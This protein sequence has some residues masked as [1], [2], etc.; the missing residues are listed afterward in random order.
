MSDKPER[1]GSREAEGERSV[2]AN[3]LALEQRYVLFFDFLGA[4]NA[5]VNGRA[6]EFMNLLIC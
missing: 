4:S 2:E 3:D 5:A 6:N 1:V